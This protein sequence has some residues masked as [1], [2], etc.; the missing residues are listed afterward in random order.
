M[1]FI[2]SY[3]FVWGL[4][5]LLAPRPNE[6]GI[7]W[8]GL[9]SLGETAIVLISMKLAVGPSRPVAALSVIALGVN[10][11]AMAEFKTDWHFIYDNYRN[12]IQFIEVAQAACFGLFSP[13]FVRGAR[14]LVAIYEREKRR[15]PWMSRRYRPPTML[16]SGS[17][18]PAL[19]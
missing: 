7:W 9:C 15:R 18:P 1:V 10:M 11:A 17:K 6:C 16:S 5:E 3:V 2:L 8:Y 14:K 19:Y 13:P 12:A 4:F